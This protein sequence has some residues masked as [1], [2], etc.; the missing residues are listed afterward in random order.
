MDARPLP[1]LPRCFG[2]RRRARSW[3]EAPESSPTARNEQHMHHWV[4]SLRSHWL[5]LS[6]AA[7]CLI[8]V[9]S[10][11]LAQITRS[12]EPSVF[13]APE[14]PPEPSMDTV[15]A[16]GARLESLGRWG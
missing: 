6:L 2:A 8:S 10:P 15:I 7:G 3:N 12:T 16:E 13:V 4:S 14:L 9:Q 11:A 1:R 5:L